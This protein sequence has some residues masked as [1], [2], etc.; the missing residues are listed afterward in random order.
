M[1]PTLVDIFVARQRLQGRIR[2]TPLLLAADLG[3]A[4]GAQGRWWLKLESLQTTRSFKIR[5]A[6][7]ALL[8][9]QHRP[10]ATSSGA[11][12]RAG[13][14]TAS[15]G[16]HG[17]AVAVAA[18]ALGLPATIVTPA[19]AP[20]AKLAAIRRA[21]ATLRAE[22]T[23]YDEAERIARELA[24]QEGWHYVSPYNDPDVIAGA[25]TIALEML[26]AAPTLELVVVP[27]GGGGLLS[28]IA[29]ALKAINPQI[30]IVGVEAAASPVFTTSLSQ[31][32]ITHVQVGA[33]LADGLA[34]NLEAESMTF[35]LV[36]RLVDR[37]V[38]VDEES[39]AAAMRALVF[40]EKLVAEGAGATA[41]AGVL[42][43]KVAP[44]ARETAIVVSG[45]NVDLPRVREVI[46]DATAT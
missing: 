22:A 45:G 20:A 27:L 33:T 31:R 5:G 17:S 11:G 16:N 18:A 7:N 1:T 10:E 25:G 14:V 6:F 46:G 44:A 32:R 36:R 41:L 35:D 4:A 24:A 21:G 42:S 12:L 13:V 43:G 29:I 3:A 39:I 26:E 2:T 15:A 40:Y 9:L 34:G 37:V 23:D 30:E 8:A 38:A 28:G 19:K